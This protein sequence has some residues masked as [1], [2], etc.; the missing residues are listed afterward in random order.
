MTKKIV[1]NEMNVWSF[2]EK[3][4]RK[5][6]SELVN[7]LGYAIKTCMELAR[8][9]SSLP[10]IAQAA[11]VAQELGRAINAIWDGS[12]SYYKLEEIEKKEMQDDDEITNLEKHIEGLENADS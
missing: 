10:G 12:L 9:Q 1:P 6:D 3:D 4:E 11:D 8:E 2:V 5:K 7:D